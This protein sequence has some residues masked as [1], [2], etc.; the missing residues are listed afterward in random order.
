MLANSEPRLLAKVWCIV[1][2]ETA[3]FSSKDLDNLMGNVL[4]SENFETKM[5]L[6]LKRLLESQSSTTGISLY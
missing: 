3:D 2:P 1:T 4:V 6:S 5:S